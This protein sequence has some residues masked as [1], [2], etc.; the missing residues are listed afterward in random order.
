MTDGSAERINRSKRFYRVSFEI[1][2][3]PSLSDDGV[4]VPIAEL[5]WQS[6]GGRGAAGLSEKKVVS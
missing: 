3:P 6:R 5:E 2:V 1:E 4:Q